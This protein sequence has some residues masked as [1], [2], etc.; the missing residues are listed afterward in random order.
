MNRGLNAQDSLIGARIGKIKKKGHFNKKL[1]FLALSSTRD[2]RTICVRVM[3]DD[4]VGRTK[5]KGFEK[6]NIKKHHRTGKNC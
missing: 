5:F 3:D 1:A 6:E 4:Q 2:S